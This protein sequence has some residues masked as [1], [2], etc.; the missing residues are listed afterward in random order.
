MKSIQI[1]SKGHAQVVTD[2]PLPSLPPSDYILVKV[3][4]VALN[5]TDW[6]HIERVDSKATVG[7]DFAGIVEEVGPNPSKSFQKGDRVAGFVHGSHTLRPDNGA[8]AEYVYAKPGLVLKIP[9]SMSFEEAAG[10]GV[11]VNTVGQGMYQEMKLPWPDKPLKEKKQILIYGGSSGMGAVGIQFAKLSGFE[12]LTTCSPRNFDYVKSLGA[13]H[14][15]DA[16]DPD[17]GKKIREF[18]N[19]KL[20]YVWDCVGEN[21]SIEQSGDALATEA[22]PGQEVRYGNILNPEAKQR[23]GVICTWSVGYS[24]LGEEWAIGWK[25]GRETVPGKPEHYEWSSKWVDFVEQLLK[26]GKFKPHRQDVR[27]GG[28]NGVLDGLKEMKE[29]KVSGHKLVYRIAEP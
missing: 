8:F 20:Y 15:F 26:D 2:A 17:V 23:D 6:K 21:G 19:N 9:D 14:V 25:G 13:D 11:A 16:Y 27:G 5:P 12:V 4:A 28:L 7:C 29:G 18:T 3:I 1:L 10:L 24:A 22:P